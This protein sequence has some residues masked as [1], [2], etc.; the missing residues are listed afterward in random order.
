[1]QCVDTGSDQWA[2]IDLC[3]LPEAAQR[4]YWGFVRSGQKDIAKRYLDLLPSHEYLAREDCDNKGV[5][6]TPDLVGRNKQIIKSVIVDKESAGVV[7]RRHNLSTSAVYGILTKHGYRVPRKVKRQVSI[8]GLVN[9]KKVETVMEFTIVISRTLDILYSSK[10]NGLPYLNHEDIRLA[11]KDKYKVL[12]RRDG[13][14]T[15]IFRLNKI[16]KEKFGYPIFDSERQT[17]L[18]RNGNAAYRALYF[19]TPEY[20]DT[21][22]DFEDLRG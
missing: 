12:E 19:F 1:M 22:M 15:H 4:Q 5:P 3:S 10:K 7:A 16:F 2:R 21:I 6:K 13:P 14:R 20:E 9:D 18:L 11:I 8:S 17:F